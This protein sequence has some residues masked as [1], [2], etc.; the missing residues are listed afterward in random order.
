M[1]YQCFDVSGNGLCQF[2]EVFGGYVVVV[3]IG[4][5]VHHASCEQP[6]SNFMYGVVCG[7]YEHQVLDVGLRISTGNPCSSL[8][9]VSG[10]H[11]GVYSCVCVVCTFHV[12]CEEPC[13]N[14]SDQRQYGE[15][16]SDAV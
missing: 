2:A 10:Y 14:K 15:I 13:D 9:V 1:V 5:T 3:L 6:Q 16:P 11:S 4:I 7:Y 12:P 8:Y